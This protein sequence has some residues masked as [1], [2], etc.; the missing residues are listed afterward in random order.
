MLD[1]RGFNEWAG[2]YNELIDRFSK[3]YPFE[4]YY[5]VLEYVQSL[6][7]IK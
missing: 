3:G 6:I 2:E 7:D 5:S 4:G 1:K